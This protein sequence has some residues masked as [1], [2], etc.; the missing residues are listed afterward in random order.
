MKLKTIAASL[1]MLG[2]VSTPVLA[3]HHNTNMTNSAPTAK[4][5]YKDYKD[6]A[7]KVCTLSPAVITMVEMN[8]NVGRS[9]PNPCNP[10]WYDRIRV[11]GGINVDVGKWGNRN[12]NFM[13]ENYQTLSLNDVYLN[14]AGNVNDWTNIFASLSYNTATTNVNP[15]VFNRVGAAEYSAAYSNNINGNANNNLQVEQAFGVFGNADAAPVYLQVGKSFQDFSR[16]EIHPITRSLT[17]VMSETLATSLKLGFIADG[18]NGG[19]YVFNDPINKVTSTTRPTNYGVSL[20]YDLN[21]DVLGFDLGA[22]YL[23]NIIAANDIAYS[24]TNFTNGGYNN[25]VG[26]VA[27]YGDV[28][29]GPFMFA[30]RYTQAVQRFNANDLTKNGSAGICTACV[31]GNGTAAITTIAGATGAKPWAAGLQAGYGFDVWGKSQN[32][33][34]GYQASREAAGLNLPKG[35]WLAGYGVDVVK[36]TMVGIEWDHDN[37]YSTGNGGNSK[38]TNLVSVRAATKF[39]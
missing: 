3:N 6:M 32:V 27:L 29:Y 16:Y 20:G 24:V 35:R 5:D 2:L 19:V 9:L 39:G 38:N 11:S 1:C 31:L 22:G 28:N 30:A 13:G 26:G 15:S 14:V 33:Y 7:P 18:F 34:L 12:A 17:Q 10:G 4:H 23:Y 21:N 37:A 8:Q 36:D 25:R